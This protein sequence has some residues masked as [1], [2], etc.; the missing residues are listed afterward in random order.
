MSPLLSVLDVAGSV[1]LLL[2]GVHMV[3]TGV[4]RA[5]GAGLRAFL[6]NALRNRAKA[7]LAG[8]AVAALTT[9]GDRS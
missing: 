9:T 4:Q 1:A 2:W 3:Q 5:F 7:F 8:V 6:G